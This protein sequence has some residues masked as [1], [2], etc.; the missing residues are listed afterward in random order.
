MAPAKLNLGLEV[1]GRRPDGYHEIATIFLAIDLVDLLTVALS[2]KLE[3]ECSN[4]ALAGSDN[5]VLKALDLLRSESA[6]AKGL[7]VRLQKTIPEAAGLGGAS[8]DAAAA[9]LAARDVWGLRQTDADLSA[10][11]ARLGSDVPFF[12]RGGCAMGRGRGELLEFLPIPSN[13]WFVV[14]VPPVAIP[15]K[16]AT[17]YGALRASDFT[18]GTRIAEQAS[19]LQAGQ[20]IDPRLLGNAF[21]R[22]LASMAPGLADLRETMKA[23]GAPSCALS[24]AGPAHYAIVGDPEEAS[25]LAARVRERLGNTKSVFV[26][27]PMEPR[28]LSRIS[29]M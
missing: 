17:L 24:G 6:T 25:R 19:R 5:L 22:P 29:M 23:A 18:E 16:T 26:V 4:P 9:L 20:E 11:A 15:R 14:V 1:L 3:L 2:A 10:L 21:S 8:S 7:M 27:A 12:L 28:S 13:V